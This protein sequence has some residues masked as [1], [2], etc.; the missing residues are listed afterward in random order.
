MT[1]TWFQ[2]PAPDFIAASRPASR[3]G[4]SILHFLGGQTADVVGE[5]AVAQTKIGAPQNDR[6]RNQRRDGRV[7]STEERNRATGHGTA[8][9]VAMKAIVQDS[10][11]EAE[12]VMRLAEIDRPEIGEGEVL[13]RVRAAGVDRGVW[14]LMTG[15]PYLL[16]V[17][18]YCGVRAPRTRVR[19]SD[20]AGRVEA[21]GADVTGLRPGDE[22]YGVAD[23]AFAEYAVATAD[24]LAPKPR[25]LSAE[26]AAAV[27][28]SGLTALQAVRDG[29]QVQPGQ[30]VLI[31]GA[32]GGVGTFAVQVARAYGAHVT[33]VCSR[34][35]VD[36]VRSLGADNV[37]DYAVGDIADDGQRYDVVL[38]I[39]G[40]RSLT[41]LR[42][43]LTAT[44]RLV[45]IGSETGG[46]WLGGFDRSLRAPLLSRFVRQT[47]TMLANS[48]NASDLMVLTDLIESDEVTPAID[49]IY[50]LSET[51]AAIRY[52]ID[53]HA[54]GKVVVTV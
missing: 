52:L 13:L 26:Q 25:N 17:I 50:P 48:E 24:K 4:G 42:R 7:I 3:A 38:D 6:H 28:I 15:L 20:V 46:R 18:G 14:H 5:R 33:G 23:G 22:V 36:L 34:A 29:G 51:P 54:Q 11:G 31:I 43:A 44:G 37:I 27:P 16:R 2:G 41:H 45:I 9:A 8:E 1:A 32:S 19:G 39:G 10:Y 40:H 47:L 35:K 49:R 12:D 53:G 30:K 21:V